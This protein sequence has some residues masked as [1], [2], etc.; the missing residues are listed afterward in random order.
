MLMGEHSHT[1]DAKG[2]VI[3]PAEFREELGERFV[4]TRGLETCLWVFGELEWNTLSRKLAALPVSKKE[5]RDVT[6]FFMAGARQLACDRP[7]R[8]LLPAHL[9][10]YARLS[11]DAV[12]NGMIN[13]VEV[14][15]KAE[16][17]SYSAGI[18]PSVTNLAEALADL[19]I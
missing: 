15:S 11:K 3:L 7:G 8:C 9:G 1:V 13:R 18:Q 2:R 12:L 10:D 14:W 19:G 5:V 17:E 6:R 16:W 4:I